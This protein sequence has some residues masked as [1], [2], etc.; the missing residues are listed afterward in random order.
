MGVRAEGSSFLDVDGRGD[1][2]AR[3]G[4]GSGCGE[5]LV[6]RAGAPVGRGA[7]HG[8]RARVRR[9]AALGVIAIGTGPR[10]TC[11]NWVGHPPPGHVHEVRK[12]PL[13]FYQGPQLS[14]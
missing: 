5:G 1:C 13:G 3:L 2:G 10:G 6:A 8:V 9:G 11:A 12:R 14:R 7:A 4:A